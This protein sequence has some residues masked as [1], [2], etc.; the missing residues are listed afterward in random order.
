MRMALGILRNYQGQP[1]LHE[2]CKKLVIAL[3]EKHDFLTDIEVVLESS[4]VVSGEFGMAEMYERKKEEIKSWLD[5]SD[6]KI[7]HFA[8]RYVKNLE[9]MATNERKRAEESIKLRKFEYPDDNE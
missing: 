4:G 3:P 1:F 6:D 2:I 5:D 9:H 8:E 7:R